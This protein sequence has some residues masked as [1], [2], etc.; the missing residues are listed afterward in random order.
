MKPCRLHYIIHQTDI[1]LPIDNFTFC[2]GDDGY[3][4]FVVITIPFFL[5]SWLINGFIPRVT[6]QVPLAEQELFTLPWHLGSPPAFCWVLVAQ[7]LVFSVVFCRSLFVLWSFF[8]LPLYCVLRFMASDYPLNTFQVF[9][10]KHVYTCTY[11]FFS[12]VSL[13][14]LLIVSYL[15]VKHVITVVWYAA[16]P[17]K[18]YFSPTSA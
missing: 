12:L 11:I 14:I 9:V 3:V 18:Q 7:S 4:T 8:F 10:V 2:Q 1:G 13:T 15:L 5:H 17:S 16:I 6:R